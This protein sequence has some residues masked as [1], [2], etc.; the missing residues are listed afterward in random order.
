MVSRAAVS[1]RTF[2]AFNVCRGGPPAAG[3]FQP[4]RSS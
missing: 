2:S 4:V 3:A 1:S